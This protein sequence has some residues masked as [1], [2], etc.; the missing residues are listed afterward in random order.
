M[1]SEYH[2]QYTKHPTKFLTIVQT[3]VSLTQGIILQACL[4]NIVKRFRVKCTRKIWFAHS[5]KLPLNPFMPLLDKNMLC[6]L[7][8]ATTTT[9][10][11][12]SCMQLIWWPTHTIFFD[13]KNSNRSLYVS[14]CLFTVACK[15]KNV[16][17]TF[18]TSFLPL[19]LP[20]TYSNYISV[21]VLVMTTKI[22]AFV[23]FKYSSLLPVRPSVTKMT[24][25][26]GK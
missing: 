6:W 3:K 17:H 21:I 12:L 16:M 8:S 11:F 14:Y 4:I 10:L 5:E 25:D 9:K 18:H 2:E 26:V 19:S 20:N 24:P 7:S 1:V 23:T 13:Y 15:R 22:C